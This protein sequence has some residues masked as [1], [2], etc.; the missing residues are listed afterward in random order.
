MKTSKPRCSAAVERQDCGMP[1]G[2]TEKM[3]IF[4]K[5]G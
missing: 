5:C 3:Q 2:A 1:S 4:E